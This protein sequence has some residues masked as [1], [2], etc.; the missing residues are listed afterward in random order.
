MEDIHESDP[1]STLS[2][3]RDVYYIQSGKKREVRDFQTYLNLKTQLTKGKGEI[4]DRTFINFLAKT[5]LDQIPDGPKI[6]RLSDTFVDHLLINI[7][8]QTLIEYESGEEAAHPV[9]F[10]E[11]V[12]SEEGTNNTRP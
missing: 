11:E 12:E 9:N 5:T 6:F 7:Y 10:D 1:E 8:P 3:G 4:D 2:S